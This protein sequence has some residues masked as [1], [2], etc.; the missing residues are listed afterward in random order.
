MFVPFACLYGCY[1]LLSI[2]LT[3]SSSSFL[4]YIFLCIINS[5]SFSSYNLA[6]TSILQRLSV[7]QHAALNSLRRV[8][9]IV[10]TSLFFDISLTPLKVFG[11]VIS[12]GSF[13][14]YSNFREKRGVNS[15]STKR[16]T[17]L[18]PSVMD[19]TVTRTI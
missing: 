5:V 16:F 1:Q 2:E 14:A 8:F 10:V 11:I 17:G 15:I 9:A 19:S 7:V 3:F 18:L 6:S 13:I 4:K 12:I